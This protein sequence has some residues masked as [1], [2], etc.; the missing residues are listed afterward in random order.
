MSETYNHAALKRLGLEFLYTHRKCKYVGV[1]VAIGKYIYD[2]VG[3]DGR[4]VQ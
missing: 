4:R 2:V 1:E 3:T